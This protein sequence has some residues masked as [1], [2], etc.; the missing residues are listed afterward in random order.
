M[1]SEQLEKIL[2]DHKLW[3]QGKGG[4]SADLRYADL[5]YADLRSADLRSADLRHA[6]LRYANFI[7][8]DL[9]NADLPDCPQRP[10][11]LLQK[12]A[13]AIRQPGALDMEDWHCGTAHCLAGWAVELT[14]GAKE[15]ESKTSTYLAGR[16][17]IP[18][19]E[20]FFFSDN[21]TALQ[22]TEK[23]LKPEGAQT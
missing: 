7:D 15:F 1:N 10:E 17:L 18:E 22:E 4:K 20:P 19:L 16:L 12:I 9:T 14:P 2:A 23:Y 6:D 21:E 13:A 8:A 5:R 11:D 3:L